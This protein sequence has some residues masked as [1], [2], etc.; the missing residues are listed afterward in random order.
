MPS[1]ADPFTRA[2]T[3]ARGIQLLS[4]GEMAAR[5]ATYLDDGDVMFAAADATRGVAIARALAAMTPAEVIFCPGSD[6]L[7]GDEAPA[8]PVN[9]GQRV[10]AL[11]HVR[12]VL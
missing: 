5:L 3:P 2:L 7:P 11:R 9:V 12:L 10:A 8:S 1:T 4:V 6:A